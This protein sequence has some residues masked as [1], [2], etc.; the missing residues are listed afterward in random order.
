MPNCV[1][2][3]L[4]KG[5]LQAVF[6]ELNKLFNLIKRYHYACEIFSLLMQLCRIIKIVLPDIIYIASHNLTLKLV[7]VHLDLLIARCIMVF[8]DR[9][10]LT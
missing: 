1:V 4:S 6:N 8:D 7:S 10:T 5:C 2:S 3:D 9:P